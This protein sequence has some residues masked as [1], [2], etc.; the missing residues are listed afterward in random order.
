MKS[1][2]VHVR[3]CNQACWFVLSDGFLAQDGTLWQLE[4]TFGEFK[5]MAIVHSESM[6][7]QRETPEHA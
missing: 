3:A 6:G 2:V 5:P 4:D 1:R 7:W